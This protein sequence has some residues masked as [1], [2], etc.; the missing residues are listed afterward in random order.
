MCDACINR[1]KDVLRKLSSEDTETLERYIAHRIEQETDLIGR[2]IES[3]KSDGAEDERELAQKEFDKV[4]DMLAKVRREVRDM[5]E[6]IDKIPRT[7][8]DVELP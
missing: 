1:I 7:L 5:L 4:H 3:A 8:S 2:N 6:E